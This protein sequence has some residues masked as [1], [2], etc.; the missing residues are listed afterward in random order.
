MKLMGIEGM[1]VDG[2]LPLTPHSDVLGLVG[3]AHSYVYCFVAVARASS[4][5]TNVRISC[6]AVAKIASIF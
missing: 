3:M 1:A 4:R 2:L 6:A 5:N